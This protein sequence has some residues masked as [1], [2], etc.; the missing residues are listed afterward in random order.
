MAR[1]DSAMQTDKKPYYDAVIYYINN[2][3][4]MNKALPW[5]NEL[6]KVPGIAADGSQILES[7]RTAKKGR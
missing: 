4:D 1:I 5:A 7:P 2:D 6:D 3:K